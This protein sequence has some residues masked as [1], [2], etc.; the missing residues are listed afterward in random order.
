MN[1]GKFRPLKVD[2][3]LTTT[4]ETLDFV[5][6]L[7][8]IFIPFRNPAHVIRFTTTRVASAPSKMAQLEAPFSHYVVLF[9]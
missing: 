8:Y 1:S 2:F 3:G 6:T 9:D 5:I 7:F 4:L